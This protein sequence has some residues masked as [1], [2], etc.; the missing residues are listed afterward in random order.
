M[1]LCMITG[2]LH[3]NWRPI[4]SVSNIRVCNKTS[5][6]GCGHRGIRPASTV[7]DDDDEEKLSYRQ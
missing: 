1:I 4:L 7:D 5:C 2:H 6:K 3:C